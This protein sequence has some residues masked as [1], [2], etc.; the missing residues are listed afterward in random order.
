MYYNDS[1]FS[2]SK[3]F[4]DSQRRF[5]QERLQ[6]GVR[7]LK[8]TYLQFSRCYC[9][10]VSFRNIVALIAHYDDTPFWISAGTNKDDLE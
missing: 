5:L 4:P 9:F 3:L 7:S 1:N 8:S 10:D 6:T 2:Q